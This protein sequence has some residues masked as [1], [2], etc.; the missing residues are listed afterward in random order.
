MSPL[1]S[2]IE[3]CA[4]ACV[5]YVCRSECFKVAV[6]QIELDLFKVQVAS[7]SSSHDVFASVLCS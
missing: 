3:R 4:T 5:N 7:V 1:P 6:D 2:P